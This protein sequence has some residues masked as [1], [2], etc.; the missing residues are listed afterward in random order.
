MKK[1]SN[2]SLFPTKRNS[3]PRN[4]F[5]L[6]QHHYFTKPSGML[7]PI[8]CL[9]VQPGDYVDLTT[10]AFTRTQTL[11]SAAFTRIRECVDY[12]F[13][14]YTVLWRWWKDFISS[15]NNVDS[16]LNPIGNSSPT[17][18]PWTSGASIALA[19]GSTATDIHGYKIAENF[20]RLLDMCG[21]PTLL[22]AAKTATLYSGQYKSN[23]FNVFR[24][25]AFARLYL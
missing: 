24:L 10:R 7:T 21:Y 12:Y 19:L 11:N 3:L 18:V 17:Q 9:D 23:H 5:D 16:A 20:N 13:I 14:S 15:V 1:T 25:Y 22:D 2:P 8:L 4:A 6:S